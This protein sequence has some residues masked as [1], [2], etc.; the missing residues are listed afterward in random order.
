MQYANCNGADIG[1]IQS[2]V[3]WMCPQSTQQPASN[4][5]PRQNVNHSGCVLPH[6]IAHFCVDVREL[7]VNSPEKKKN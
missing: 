7:W 2:N 1:N 4:S 5:P 3:K 6:G